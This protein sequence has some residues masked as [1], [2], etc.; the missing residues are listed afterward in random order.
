MGT[1]LSSR[2]EPRS[3]TARRQQRVLDDG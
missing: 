2:S 1:S 3:G